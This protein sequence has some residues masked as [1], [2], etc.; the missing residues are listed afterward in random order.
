MDS[1]EILNHILCPPG[2]G[3]FTVETA[4]ERKEKLQQKLY[5]NEDCKSAW[6]KSL[7]SLKDSPT[8]LLG[9][10]SDTGGG[11]L[12]GANW[13][14]LALREYLNEDYFDVGDIRVVPHLL[15]DNYLNTKTIEN[16]RHALYQKSCDLPV[17]PLSLAELAIESILEV[18]PKAKIFSIGG[19]HSVSAALVPPF[20]KKYPNLGILHFDAHTDLLEERLGIDKC[21]ATWAAHILPSL[22]HPQNMA[23]VGIRRSGQVKE[24]WEKKFGISQYWSQDVFDLGP[25]EISKK[26]IAQF[27]AKGIKDVY[28][29]FDID[30]I[31]SEYASATGTPETGGLRPHE[32]SIIIDSVTPHFNIVGADMVELAPFINHHGSKPTLAPEPNSTFEVAGLLSDKM[33]AT[34]KN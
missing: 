18:N 7:G 14:P 31:D 12:R 3:V 24:F 34:F 9:V 8:V 27:N 25:D 29:S 6:L 20:I 5:G 17:S 10:P 4:K 13:G 16:V 30:A 2:D 19:D 32:A 1:N 15:H 11:I 33:I 26:I 28:I 23:Q 21:F 22:D